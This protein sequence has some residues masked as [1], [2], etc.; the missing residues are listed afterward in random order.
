MFY[1]KYFMQNVFY[2]ELRKDYTIIMSEIIIREAIPEDIPAIKDTVRDV[3]DWEEV[4]ESDEL[5]NACIALYFSPVLHEATFGRVAVLDGKVVGVVFASVEGEPPGYKHLL[6][7]LSPYIL[8]LLQST[9][10]DRKSIFDY[11]TKTSNV[12]RELIS[13]VEEQYDGTLEFLAL[14]ESAQG[15]GIGKKLWLE[16]KSYFEEKNASRIYLY[17]DSEC[18]FEFYDSQGFKKRREREICFDFDGEKE[19]SQQYLY[20]YDL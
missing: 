8:T 15:K 11:I 18:N 3:W 12:Y 4:F 20:E 19:I 16:A 9:D 17:S 10:S 14:S 2:Q 13:G 5:L 1:A 6:E 7:D